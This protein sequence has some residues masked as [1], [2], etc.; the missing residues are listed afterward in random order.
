MSPKERPR[1]T[2]CLKRL[3]V[4]E[5]ASNPFV[6]RLSEYNFLVCLAGFFRIKARPVFGLGEVASIF[7]DFQYCN[8]YIIHVV[9]I[10]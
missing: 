10:S 8:G 9:F 7:I 5:R 4:P 3:Y 2:C 1:L 6:D